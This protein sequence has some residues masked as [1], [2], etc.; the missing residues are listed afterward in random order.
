MTIAYLSAAIEILAVVGTLATQPVD[1]A[2]TLTAPVNLATIA[3]L[4]AGGAIAAGLGG[5]LNIAPTLRWYLP[6]HRPDAAQQRAA[7]HIVRRQFIILSATWGASGLVLVALNYRTGVA[8][9]VLIVLSV[10]FASTASAAS[11]LLFAQRILRPVVAAIADV[12]AQQ[13]FPGVMPR[14]VI[15]WTVVGAMPSVVTVVLIVCRFNGWGIARHASVEA[16]LAV[17]AVVAL[18]VGIPALILVARSI[19]DP[20]SEVVNAMARVQFGELNAQVALSERSEIGWLQS[21]FN[22]M[23]GGLRERERIRDLFGRHV[24]TAVAA[25]AVESGMPSKGEVAEVAVL[26]IDLVNSTALAARH[27]PE[28]VAEL[29]ND[30]FRIVVAVV[31]DQDGLVNKF[32][33]DAALAVFG[34]PDT[35][36]HPAVR[37]LTAARRLAQKLRDLSGVDFGIGVSAGPVFA[38]YIGAENRY[39]YTVIGDAV[40]EAARLADEAKL[41]PARTLCSLATVTDSGDE[42]GHRWV[43]AG[44]T[45]L[46]GRSEITHMLAP[47]N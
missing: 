43:S 21:G 17:I 47:Q 19:A 37:A 38:G 5:Y 33:G 29:L 13:R 42:E 23:V 8:A 1:A 46:R 39:E 6:A 12:D 9:S 41:T 32:Q 35:I 26:F 14:L 11:S 16:P 10:F 40:N 24:G 18:L 36:E 28:Q 22:E 3:V 7:V 44:S 20:I 15:L 2:R 30:F 45:L 25:L 27:P 31:E 4:V 34:V